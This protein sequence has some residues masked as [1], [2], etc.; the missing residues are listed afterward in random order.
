MSNIPSRT[1]LLLALFCFPAIAFADVF[2][3]IDE[4]IAV[5]TLLAY[6][7]IS[8]AVAVFFW[9]IVKFI[10]NAGDEKTIDEGKKMMIWGLVGLFVIVGIWGIVGFIQESLGIGGGGGGTTIGIPYKL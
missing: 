2:A 1:L 3:V 4:G 5:F 7:F 6:L 10:W 9:G 8:C